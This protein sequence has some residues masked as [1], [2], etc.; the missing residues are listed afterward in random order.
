MFLSYTITNFI[1]Y[2]ML[3]IRCCYRHFAQVCKTISIEFLTFIKKNWGLK[4]NSNKPKVTVFAKGGRKV[5]DNAKVVINETEVETVCHHK[6]LGINI[7]HT[8][9]FIVAEENLCLKASRALFSIKQDVF[10][11][12]VKPSVIFRIFDSLVKPIAFY[13]N[14]VWFGYKT[15]FHNKTIDQMF[16]MPLKSYNGFDKTFTRFYKYILGVH[17]KTSTFAVCS[18]LGQVLL[19]TSVICSS[20]SFSLH[21]ITSKSDSLTFKAYLDQFSTTW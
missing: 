19:I 10:N 17:S 21:T 13:G 1:T 6:Y 14:E 9:T 11:N 3:T 8:W 16:E 4:I 15:S 7:S 12:N 18:E 2:C 20:I 5:K